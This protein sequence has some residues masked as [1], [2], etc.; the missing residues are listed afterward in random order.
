MNR[1]FTTVVLAAALSG[2][3]FSSVVNAGNTPIYGGAMFNS[4]TAD[5]VNSQDMFYKSLTMSVADGV[6][7][8]FGASNSQGNYIGQIGQRITPAGLTI[9]GNLGTGQFGG[10]SM[11]T[12]V[13]A[14][15]TAV[16]YAE[17]YNS[18]GDDLGSR[19]VRWNAGSATPIEL[20]T[21]GTG[22][23]NG[24][25]GVGQAYAT[26]IAANGAA[27]G[28]SLKYDS[29]GN[30]I[31]DRAVRW[32]AAGHIT[33]LSNLSKPDVIGYSVYGHTYVSSMNASGTLVGSIATPG[34]NPYSSGSVPVKWD[35]AGVA[36][37]LGILG[38]DDGTASGGSTNAGANQINNSGIS[39]GYV[40]KYDGSG[41]DLGTRAV[42][43]DANGTVHELAG[44]LGANEQATDSANAINAF[45]VAVGVATVSAPNDTRAIRW[46]AS[47]TPTVLGG[48][49]AGG[50]TTANAINDSGLTVGQANSSSTDFVAHA[51]LWG[52]DGVAVD[53]NSLIDSASG[54]TLS[55][56]YAISANNWVSG[57]GQ[58][59]PD[60]TG[61]LQP[62]TR[63]FLIQVPEPTSLALAGLGGLFLVRRV[64]RHG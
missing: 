33:E 18:S 49:V 5:G 39:V 25:A 21:D 4:D 56:A 11:P 57:I 58:Y 8:S 41:N 12:A 30:Q 32:D 59:D 14:G 23:E 60:G 36:T 31:G 15:G 54:W 3:S 26:T 29:S 13:A 48:L 52:A 24:V 16:G 47:G 34:S 19:A 64:R 7:V 63:A 42:R 27:A 46:D 37:Q 45:G 43:W 28:Y 9:L 62:F 17:K 6:A 1:R 44:V 2:L 53:L 38:T 51:V 35:T 22:T 10:T 50:S 40:Q 20:E 55:T 61:D